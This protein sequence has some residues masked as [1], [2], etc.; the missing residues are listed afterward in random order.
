MKNSYLQ[1]LENSRDEP[2]RYCALSHFQIC[3]MKFLSGHVSVGVA[4]KH[5][6]SMQ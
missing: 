3:K 1:D 6:I 5:M 2:K 4:I